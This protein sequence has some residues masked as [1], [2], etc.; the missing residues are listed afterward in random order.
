MVCGCVD[1]FNTSTEKLADRIVVEGGITTQPPPYLVTLSSTSNFSQN[2]DGISRFISGA[3]I[4]ICADDGVCIPLFEV[5][6][7]KYS[8]AID[9][10]RGE[11]GKSY[12]VKIST[13]EGKS[14]QSI[15]EKINSS[16]PITRGYVEYDPVT[17]RDAGFQV[18]IDSEDTDQEKN[19]YKWETENFYPYSGFCF[20]R[21]YEKEIGRISSDK[22]IDGNTLSR[23]KVKSVPF[24]STSTWVVQVYQL[25]ISET[26]FE[27]FDLIKKQTTTTGSIFDPP[28]SFLRGNLVNN[29]NPDEEVLGYFV[30]AGVSRL[31]VVIDRTVSG[32]SPRPF[33][34]TVNDPIYCGVPCNTL[35][36]AFN[37]GKCGNRPCPPDCALL[38]GKTNVAPD[39]WPYPHRECE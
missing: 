36:V 12:H 24:E 14:I 17:L 16:P 23:V 39:A 15:P 28:P 5:S 8:T 18:Y 9:V 4:T 10:V 11:I 13:A 1:T 29:S 33:V 25:A 35:C 7:G 32:L 20:N 37:G 3:Q 2:I 34:G 26:A 30:V 19:F 6:K 21:I 31:D 22:F 38:S 27:Y